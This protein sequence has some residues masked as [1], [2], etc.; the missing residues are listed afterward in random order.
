MLLPRPKCR[1]CFLAHHLDHGNLALG[2]RLGDFCIDR[3]IIKA[4]F[5][6]VRCEI[7]KV[8][9]VNPSPVDCTQAHWAGFAG[10]IEVTAPELE[11]AKFLARL[12]DGQHF[13]VRR[14]II[15]RRN[16]IRALRYD[17]AFFDDDGAEGAAAPGAYILEREL[18]GASHES[19]V[20][21]A[22]FRHRVIV[23]G[24]WT[25]TTP[26]SARKSV[27]MDSFAADVKADV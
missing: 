6:S 9:S 18:N 16:L 5:R 22:W 19:F 26:G 23:K 20:H 11:T 10:G 15:H 7:R 12:A 8:H 24:A 2:V 3:G 14:R 21:V 25:P 4:D 17:D 13:S 27:D 1:Q